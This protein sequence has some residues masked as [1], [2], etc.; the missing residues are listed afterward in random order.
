MMTGEQKFE[1][2]YLDVLQ[3][4]EFG[5]VRVYREHPELSDWDALDA[6]EAL[7][8]SYTAETRGRPR[9]N[10]HLSDLSQRVFNS[11]ES[12][13][14]WRLGREQLTAK[15]REPFELGIEPKTVH[16]IIDC[17]KRVRKSIHR[18]NKEGGRQ[19]YLNF[20]SEFVR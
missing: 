16:E 11:V 1:E 20:V 3:N 13:C 18:W 17:L 5:I 9:S 14:E 10:I 2:K 7:I 19:G 4:I 8:R 15:D 6:I 12:L